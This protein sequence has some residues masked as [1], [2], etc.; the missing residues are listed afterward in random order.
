MGEY[1]GTELMRPI[2]SMLGRLKFRI[3][4]L[5]AVRAQ[6]ESMGFVIGVFVA[7]EPLD[8][9][10]DSRLLA[11]M[12]SLRLDLMVSSYSDADS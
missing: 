3:A 10:F 6:A 7:D 12:A 11:D 2:S 8:L 1:S 9:D 5:E 4:S